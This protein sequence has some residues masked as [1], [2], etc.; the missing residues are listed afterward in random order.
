ME[1]LET[2]EYKKFK[3]LFINREVN[4]TRANKIKFSMEKHGFDPAKAISVTK[5]FEIIDG[6]H[7]FHAAQELGIAIKYIVDKDFTPEKLK[8]FNTTSANWKSEDY[9]KFWEGYGR[10]DYTKLRQFQEKVNFPLPLLTFWLKD[11]DYQR[12]AKNKDFQE[13]KFQFIL[14]EQTL[15]QILATSKLLN[16]LKEQDKAPKR[17]LWHKIFH[18]ALKLFFSSPVVDI[19]KFFAQLPRCMHYIKLMP[20]KKEYLENLLS[21]YNYEVRS[22]NR[23]SLK[24]DGR[25]TEITN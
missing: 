12:S 17:L 22:G 15:E 10:T 6:Q 25:N 2:K 24:D 1:I 3:Y 14:D 23:L 4:K 9:L 21:I 7:R 8:D 19:N 16:I 5:D 20:T 11:K 18:E 13:G